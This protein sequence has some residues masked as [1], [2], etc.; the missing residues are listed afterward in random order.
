MASA[1]EEVQASNADDLDTGGVAERAD[2]VL[3]VH[4][5]RD[6]A[7]ATTAIAHLSLTRAEL[8]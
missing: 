7:L 4:G 8:A 3:G 5:E 1:L 2:D 6:A